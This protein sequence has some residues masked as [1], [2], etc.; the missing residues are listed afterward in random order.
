V[1]EG[2]NSFSMPSCIH[3]TRAP[4]RI[5]S[6]TMKLVSAREIGDEEVESSS[7]GGVRV[8]P[9][10]G[11]RGESGCRLAAHRA[12]R[13][14]AAVDELWSALRDVWRRWP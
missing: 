8:T 4:I 12:S 7:P 1:I 14:Q 6:S 2:V 3:T 11:L 5:A 10:Q 13:G 9:D